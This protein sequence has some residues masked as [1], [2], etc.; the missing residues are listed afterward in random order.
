MGL[1]PNRVYMQPFDVANKSD[2]EM[3]TVRFRPSPGFPHGRTVRLPK[4]VERNIRNNHLYNY[5]VLDD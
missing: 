2:E 4:S 5:E 1:D 3:V